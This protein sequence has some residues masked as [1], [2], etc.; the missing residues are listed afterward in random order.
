MIIVINFLVHI[1]YKNYKNYYII[2]K[3]LVKI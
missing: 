2:N 1:S 3:V